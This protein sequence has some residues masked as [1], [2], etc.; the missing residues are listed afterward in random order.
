M[1]NIYYYKHPR[2]TVGKVIVKTV[3]TEQE[4]HRLCNIFNQD[5]GYEDENGNKY[6]LDYEYA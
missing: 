1:F 4:A 6:L 2:Y 5:G 3:E